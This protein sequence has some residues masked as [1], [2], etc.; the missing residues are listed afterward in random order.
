MVLTTQ[1]ALLVLQR[2]QKQ[3]TISKTITQRKT[4]KQETNDKGA[5]L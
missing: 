1:I 3:S 2:N 4:Q 5:L